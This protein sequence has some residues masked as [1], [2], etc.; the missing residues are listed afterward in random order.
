MNLITLEEAKAH[1][2]V[3]HDDDDAEIERKVLEASEAVLDY[4]KGLLSASPSATS[5]AQSSRT[6]TARSSTSTIVAA[7]SSAGRSRQQ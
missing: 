6:A 2:L 4:L 1:L 5:K 7:L 3:D